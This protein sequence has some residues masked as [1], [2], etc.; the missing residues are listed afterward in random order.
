MP[1][2]PLDMVAFG[3]ARGDQLADPAP[4]PFALL[5]LMTLPGLTLY[6][7]GLVRAKNILAT[8][9]LACAC[10]AL[11]TSLWLTLG[12][13]FFVDKGLGRLESALLAGLAL[14]LLTGAV[15]ERVRFGRFLLWAALWTLLVYLPAFL[16][17]QALPPPFR[18]PLGGA[19][20]QLTVGAAAFALGLRSPGALSAEALNPNSVRLSLAGSMLLHL[21]WL[22]LAA[23]VASRFGLS[24][25]SAA[26]GA[27]LA[28]WSGAGAW[29]I[30]EAAEHKKPTAVGCSAGILMG[31][32]AYSAT[33]GLVPPAGAVLVGAAAG[34]AG[35][36]AD[37]LR[38]YLPLDDP[39]DLVLIH[40]L[41]A[42]IGLLAAGWLRGDL[43]TSL[44]TVLAVG[45]FSGLAS[46][47][48]LLAGDAC[49]QLNA[50]DDELALG[51]DRA[52]HGQAGVDL[53]SAL[54]SE[55][56]PELAMPRSAAAPPA[57]ASR[58]R[59]IVEGTDPEPLREAWSG[60]CQARMRPP[61]EFLAVYPHVTTV[62]GRCFHFRGGDPARLRANLERLLRD[63]LR[64]AQIR[65]RQESDAMMSIP[66]AA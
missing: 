37:S 5:G 43:T 45:L 39:L 49:L 58:C 17:T 55:L 15:A 9:L 57:I 26:I 6:Y 63:Q 32:A 56:R 29:L 48:L 46:R 53:E 41:G 51:L 2:V 8:M 21:G 47:L 30:V 1:E 52:L 31:L 11:G 35:S 65:V 13:A 12:S 18:D 19:C 61:P 66:R 34:A 60:L 25:E 24:V 38:R 22:G 10:F 16:F 62:E 33:L 20:V 23:A 3:A 64:T 54:V 50:S 4:L 40:G 42:V 28:G 14:A 36:L 59:L 27:M 44:F 7:G